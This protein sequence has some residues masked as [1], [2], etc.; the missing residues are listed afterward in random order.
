MARRYFAHIILILLAASFV[1][2]PIYADEVLVE[3]DYR[4][5]QWIEAKG[6]DN[7]KAKKLLKE[8]KNSIPEDWTEAADISTKQLLDMRSKII[9]LAR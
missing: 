4:W 2:P 8:I 5:L 1:V 7:K 6:K 9:Q 3:G